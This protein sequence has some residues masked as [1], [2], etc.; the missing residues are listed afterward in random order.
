M[1]PIFGMLKDD[2]TDVNNTIRDLRRNF[3]NFGI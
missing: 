2:E 1:I 3:R